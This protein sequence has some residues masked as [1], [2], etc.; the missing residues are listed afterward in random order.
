MKSHTKD[1]YHKSQSLS[2]EIDLINEFPLVYSNLL[3]KYS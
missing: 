2:N 3:M 1:F